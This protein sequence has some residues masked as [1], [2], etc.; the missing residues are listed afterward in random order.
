[1][2]T[3]KPTYLIV[4]AGVFGAS[5]AHHIITSEPSAS[6]FLVDRTPF[7]CP[8][9]ASHDINKIVRADYGD[10]FYTRLALEAKEQW[11]NHPLYKGYY[12]ESG[13]LHA[14]EKEWC[15]KAIQNYVDLDIHHNARILSRDEASGMFS[16]LL[17][18]TDWSGAETILWNPN[19]GVAEAMDALRATILEAVGCGVVYVEGT[20]SKLQFDSHQK[21]IG[22]HTEDGRE[23]T[24]DYVILCTGAQTARLLANSAPDWKSLQVDGRLIAAGVVEAAVQLTAEQVERFSGAPAF[25]HESELTLGNFHT[26]SSCYSALITSLLRRNHAAYQSRSLEI[27]PRC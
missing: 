18:D 22:I 14:A 11:Y 25:A 21:C 19:S 27:L 9:A 20:V 16:G 23:I 15:E 17:K 2:D 6:V 7:P 8:Y 3:P 4:G 24:A 26:V 13:L 12:A 5:T 1:M 10:I